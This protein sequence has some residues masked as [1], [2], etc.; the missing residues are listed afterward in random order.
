MAII[1]LPISGF[2]R[3]VNMQEREIINLKHFK[4]LAYRIYINRM[5]SFESILI[6]PSLS[7][8]RRAFTVYQLMTMLEENRH[9][10]MIIEHDPLLYENAREMMEYVS[11]AMRRLQRMW[12][13][14]YIHK[15]QI[16]T[17]RSWLWMLIGCSTSMKALRI[18]ARLALKGL[19]A[20]HKLAKASIESM[21]S[22]RIWGIIKEGF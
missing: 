14:F 22:W 15:E 10:I 5:M 2:L 12:R 9:T 6:L 19:N 21:R 8:S 13:C 18:K 20:P 11:Q 16:P 7:R 1:S 4:E 3:Q 17:L